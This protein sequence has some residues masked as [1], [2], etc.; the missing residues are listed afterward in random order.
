MDS[1]LYGYRF[2]DVYE[3]VLEYFC[4]KCIWIIEIWKVI[5]FYMV[6]SCEYLS[7]EKIYNDLLL[8]YFNMSLVIV[9]NNFKVFVDEGFVIELKF[10]NYSIIY[11]DFMGY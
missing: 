6:N 8:E 9:Y 4:E 10:C 2:F 11:Y 1:Y 5:I 3:N 7:V